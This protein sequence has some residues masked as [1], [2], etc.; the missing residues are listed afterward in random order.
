M[1]ILISEMWSPL[2]LVA[3]KNSRQESLEV[4]VSF[5]SQSY[6]AVSD[7]PELSIYLESRF[8]TSQS[9][10]GEDSL[11]GDCLET[12]FNPSLKTNWVDMALDKN[13]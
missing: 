8:L 9:H 7:Q 4:L 10:I 11:S 1:L 12:H 3:G 13:T 2:L 5:G 6:L